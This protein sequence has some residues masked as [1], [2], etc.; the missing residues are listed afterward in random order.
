MKQFERG[1]HF[2]GIFFTLQVF[3]D[4]LYVGH[5]LRFFE[6]R[7]EQAWPD[8]GSFGT[9]HSV[10]CLTRDGL[11]CSSARGFGCVLGDLKPNNLGA[12]IVKDINTQPRRSVY[13]SYYP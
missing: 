1:E 3:L 13:E 6:L 8:T 9:A 12:K 5:A 2:A 10:S 4:L 11:A 7:P